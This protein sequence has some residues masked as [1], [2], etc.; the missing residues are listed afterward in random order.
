MSSLEEVSSLLGRTHTKKPL[1]PKVV[2]VPLLTSEW[3]LYF[4]K[5]FPRDCPVL[6]KNLWEYV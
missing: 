5:L 3:S 1:L 2:Q 4:P 6:G